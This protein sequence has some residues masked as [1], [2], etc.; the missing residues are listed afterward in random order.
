V[1]NP[2]PTGSAKRG[3]L[4]PDGGASEESWRVL[5]SL[6]LTHSENYAGESSSSSAAGPSRE[7]V[8]APPL[9]SVDEWGLARL[10]RTAGVTP[11]HRQGLR[12][13]NC[14]GANFAALVLWGITT[15]K[16]S[17]GSWAAAVAVDPEAACPALFQEIAAAG[18]R[19]AARLFQALREAPAE[20]ALEADQLRRGIEFRA[21]CGDAWTGFSAPKNGYAEL[22]RRASLALDALG[23]TAE[24]A[25]AGAA[26]PP[27]AEEATQA[28]ELQAWSELRQAE[29][30]R[31]A[32]AEQRYWASEAGQLW[33]AA[34][35]RIRQETVPSISTGARQFG[36]LLAIQDDAAVMAVARPW[37]DLYEHKLAS[38]VRRVLAQAGHSLTRFEWRVIDAHDLEH[39]CYDQLVALQAASAPRP[40]LAEV[41]LERN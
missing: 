12:E 7:E 4:D 9:E 18:P 32:E 11:R 21:A 20:P 24:L 29:Q 23:L 13:S 30:E 31:Q 1:R 5:N 27:T 19:A 40:A 34:L 16:T 3:I 26:E 15:G 33:R 37:R 8:E 14:S 2:G 6:K 41:T 28:A 22:R 10:I 38:V 35:E 25:E 17:P 39:N 36:A